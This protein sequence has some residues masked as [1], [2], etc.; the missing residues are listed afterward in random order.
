MTRN[1]IS[2]GN[3]Q[4]FLNELYPQSLAES[5][6]KV[7]NHFGQASDSVKKI[8]VALELRPQ[9][10]QEAIDLGIDTIV[11]HHPPIFHG[12]NRFDYADPEVAMYA[13]LIKHDIKVFALH[14][15]LDVAPNGMNDW[16]AQAL[17][18]EDI[19]AVTPDEVSGNP[20]LARMGHFSQPLT[21]TQVLA[22]I[23][24]AF[25]V[26]SLTYMESQEKPA[27]Q[28]LAVIGG[29]GGSELEDI[30][31]SGVDV[32]VTGDISHHVGH[33]ALDT[34][35]LVVDASHYIEAIFIEKMTD[36]LEKA[37]IK[38]QWAVTI[39]A[40]KANTNPFQYFN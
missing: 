23:K 2:Y 4:A 7:G 9:V 20:G 8:L 1:K 15:N 29:A 5:W 14:T 22:K 30:K 19:Q 21:R 24:S 36:I 28:S 25:K 35:M 38:K 33:Q 26:D 32:F 34:G 13:E 17:D 6:D 11:M 27:Y 40:S 18:L 12:I 39:H 31:A 3:L 10:I 37:K 16:L